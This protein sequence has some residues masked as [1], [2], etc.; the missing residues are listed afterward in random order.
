MVEKQVKV[1][2][3]NLR[4]MENLGLEYASMNRQNRGEVRGKELVIESSNIAHFKKF[5]FF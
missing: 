4:N 3:R 2:K 1:G 5:M